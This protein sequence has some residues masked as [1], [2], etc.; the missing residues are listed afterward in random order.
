[1][2][3]RY[4]V[5][6]TPAAA[7]VLRKLDQTAAKRIKVATDALCDEPRPHGAK[8]LVGRH[9]ALRIRVGDWRVIYT[10]EDDRLIVL[11]VEIGHRPEVY[12]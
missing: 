2:S 6:M 12:G 1:M 5:R 3:R 9:G 10:V 7:K 11:V 8:A 4:T